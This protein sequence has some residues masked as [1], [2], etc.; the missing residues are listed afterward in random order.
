MRWPWQRRVPAAPAVTGAP[1]D[2]GAPAGASPALA[3]R[4]P[5]GQSPSGWAFHPPLQRAIAPDMGIHRGAGTGWTATGRNPTFTGTM[6][7][8]V[9]GTSS[10]GVVDGDGG[11]LGAGTAS[12]VPAPLV[13]PMPPTSAGWRDRGSDDDLAPVS[14]PYTRADTAPGLPVLRYAIDTTPMPLATD[15]E[16]PAR[17]AGTDA[18]HAQRAMDDDAAPATAMTTVPSDD[19]P[20]DT[21]SEAAPAPV[22]QPVAHGWVNPAVTGDAPPAG[23]GGSR[24][25]SGS[26][27]VVEIPLPAGHPVSA[28]PPAPPVQRSAAGGRRLGLG[29][30]LSSGDPTGSVVHR[31]QP[32]PT[33]RATGAASSSR[34][35]APGSPTVSRSIATTAD[36]AR[37]PT[38]DGGSSAGTGEAPAVSEV[39]GGPA[40][41]VSGATSSG[42]DSDLPVGTAD[43]AVLATDSAPGGHEDSAGPGP[44][45]VQRA[46]AMPLS[47]T[48]AREAGGPGAGASAGSA[49]ASAVGDMPAAADADRARTTA[50]PEV[51]GG[52][53]TTTPGFVVARSAATDGNV[54]PTS[55]PVEPGPGSGSGPADDGPAPEHAPAG[56]RL[57]PVHTPA[58]QGPG[59][60]HATVEE[61]SG[62]AHTTAG[63]EPQ[64][65]R[66]TALLGDTAALTGPA[67]AGEPA[68]PDMAGSLTGTRATGAPD[69][70]GEPYPGENL[71]LGRVSRSPGPAAGT[72]AGTASAAAVQRS[73]DTSD[74]SAAPTPVA[75]TATSG[76]GTADGARPV[77]AASVADDATSG[78]PSSGSMGLPVQRAAATLGAEGRSVSTQGLGGPGPASSQQVP[79]QRSVGTE[80][81]VAGPGRSVPGASRSTGTVQPTGTGQPTHPAPAVA[82]SGRTGD[83]DRQA[84]GPAATVE[85]PVTTGRGAAGV[86]GPRLQR[87]AA[88]A[89]GPVTRA[90]A[91]AT[92]PVAGSAAPE[93][94][95]PAR[96]S[97]SGAT[98][99]GVPAVAQRSAVA[100]PDGAAGTDGRAGLL[101]TMAPGH[102]PSLGAATEQPGT[103][104]GLDPTDVI[105]RT[106][107]APPLAGRTPVVSRTVGSHVPGGPAASRTGPTHVRPLP[108]RTISRPGP[109]RASASAG[110]STS[111][112][113]QPGVSVLAQRSANTHGAASD[114]LAVPTAVST[115]ALRHHPVLPAL[116]AAFPP[117]DATAQRHLDVVPSEAAPS[118][119][120]AF[121]VGDVSTRSLRRRMA[122][123]HRRGTPSPSGPAA[124]DVTA[125]PQDPSSGDSATGDQGG[126]VRI[127]DVTTEAV[128][129]AGPARPEG[130]SGSGMD[131]TA[132][133]GLADALYPRLLRQIR[134]EVLLDRERRGVRTDRRVP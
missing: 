87:L 1:A 132:L 73:A 2:G 28:P 32:A 47:P 52:S 44:G 54:A 7:H 134:H 12:H 79:V 76:A 80:L 85:R 89:D 124:D 97:A 100:Q 72:A 108:W 113:A 19:S 133:A 75:T 93:H 42:A 127:D 40:P 48:A 18:A 92:L 70:S 61:A 98:A 36:A 86:L 81:P 30:P 17:H 83:V 37:T 96:P 82:P 14:Q 29:A 59:P 71:P 118:L 21:A 101:G 62:P 116:E 53:G 112:R 121:T 67:P 13:A 125:P 10:S 106:T 77:D 68:G 16:R 63:D 26:G 131:A 84:A 123:A 102:S 88:S 126:N 3:G 23:D 31:A 94:G 95:G 69:S 58:G 9:S 115:L 24:D 27:T 74:A 117:I 55:A 56:E 39:A 90:A 50:A 104:P 35:T 4:D 129:T 45:V 119:Q 6:T 114:A 65:Q 122:G 130:T 99:T 20:V 38:G 66:S 22:D 57:G 8:L 11:G 91:S 25:G 78:A 64:V 46:V 60:A 120:R 49:A 43:I 107:P 33:P 109:S 5:G 15:H 128:A 41:D 34:S 105:D 103:A 110:P 51:S 111:S